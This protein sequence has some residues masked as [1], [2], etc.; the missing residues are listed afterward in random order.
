MKNNIAT[1]FLVSFVA[2]CSALFLLLNIAS[3]QESP[4]PQPV[5]TRATELQ[6]SILSH[7]DEI[8]KLEAD[9]A[10]YQQR[11]VDVDNQ[12]KTLQ[13]AIQ[14][15]DLTR[16]KLSTDKKLT[17]VKIAQTNDSIYD[18]NKNIDQKQEHIEKNKKLISDIVH[19]IDE[20]DSETLM[21][22]ILGNTSIS[23]FLLDIDD[24][25][26]LQ[27]SIRDGIKSLERLK[28]DLSGQKVSYQAQQKRLTLLKAQ[29]ADQQHLA[30]QQRLEQAQLLKDT[31]SQESNY[32][33][34]LADKQAR[35]KQF[36]R[37]IGDFEAQLRAEIDPNS[38]PR[39][40]TKVLAYPIDD[41]VITQKFGRTSDSGRLYTSGTHNG[42]DFKAAPGTVIR[43]V[44]DGTVI[45]TGDTDHVCRGASY[46]RWVMIKHRN[47]LSTIYGHLE[48]VKVSQGNQVGV[49]DVI[50][51]SGSTGYATGPHL[52]LGLFVSSAV[53]IIDLPS[54]TCAG[55]IF[56][57]PV[58]AANGYLDPL[59]YL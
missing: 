3:A 17:Q 40:G 15:L 50:G 11:L 30:D 19:K 2:A 52:H 5:S 59:A 58:S 13:G 32:K 45:G 48:L 8:K 24:L 21:E 10:A 51:Y 42:V 28:K 35:K 20:A 39:A 41:V 33:K 57:I 34:Q 49:G 47:G 37:E 29:L 55:A 44:A 38:F 12:K 23:S 27:V 9:I 18:L 25:G 54:K 56:H 7:Q 31:K 4:S 26:R 16:V 43:A 22:V 1:I 46:G 14:T 36:E 53:H 6:Q